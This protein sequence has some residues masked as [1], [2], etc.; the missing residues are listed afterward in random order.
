MTDQSIGI[1]DL[2]I[3]QK[4]W[5][6]VVT[7][8]AVTWYVLLG[9]NVDPFLIGGYYPLFVAGI[10]VGVISGAPPKKAFLICFWGYAVISLFWV[11]YGFG[12]SSNLAEGSFFAAFYIAWAILCGLFGMWGALLR[13]LIL[14]GK[15]EN[16]TL[17][18]WQWLTFVGVVTIV[19]DILIIPNV[20]HVFVVLK[21][22][23]SLSVLFIILAVLF[24]LG[25]FIGAFYALEYKSMLR[26]AVKWSVGSHIVFLL[27][28]IA[29]YVDV[30]GPPIQ[31]CLCYLGFAALF[32]IFVVA[33]THLGYHFRNRINRE[34]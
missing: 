4:L 27:I 34:Q 8:I 30:G 24:T 1:F 20:Y 13:Q 17:K 31:Y 2:T 16:V 21:D 9:V 22:V 15:V 23:H 19:A 14:H 26:V 3:W 10:T 33:G 28:F 25:V 12:F 7:V 6:P 29:L 32:L 11:A 18:S 5:I